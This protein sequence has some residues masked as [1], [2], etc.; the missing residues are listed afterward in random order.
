MEESI[1]N[2]Q[3]EVF[4]ARLDDSDIGI[5]DLFS[6]SKLANGGRMEEEKHSDRPKVTL[7]NAFKHQ[8]E[9]FQRDP[10][11]FKPEVPENYKPFE[12][13]CMADR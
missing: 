4:G 5:D 3:R 6:F 11:S 13:G 2:F 9:E 12:F 8:G 10:F 7:M 1:P